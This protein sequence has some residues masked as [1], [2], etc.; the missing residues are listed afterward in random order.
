MLNL[1][2]TQENNAY[3]YNSNNTM[4]YASLHCTQYSMNSFLLS[5][6]RLNP[7]FFHNSRSTTDCVA[8]P[9]WSKPGVQCACTYTY[10]RY[11]CFSR[12]FEAGIKTKMLTDYA[13][14]NSVMSTQG[15]LYGNGQGMTKMQLSSDIR[16]R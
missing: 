9:A 12:G 13:S 10:Y 2:S 11:N 15:V 4:T 5:W 16:W 3:N 1:S 7:L 8:M 14:F 6:S